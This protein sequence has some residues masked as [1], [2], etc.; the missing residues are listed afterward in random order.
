MEKSAND[1][2]GARDLHLH[3]ADNLHYIRSTIERASSVT[4]VSGWGGVV[5][6]L[7]AIAAAAIAWQQVTT[8]AWLFVWLTEAFIAAV[9]GTAAMALKSRAA[10]MPLLSRAA[11]QFALSFSP[12]IAAAG[13]LTVVCYLNNLVALL[14]G[15]WLLLY[16][17]AVVSGGTFSVRPIPLTGLAMML[18]GTVALFSPPAWGDAFMAAGFGGL[19]II[20][21]I[22][23][24]RRYGG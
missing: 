7:T 20:F 16:G 12:A 8:E 23:I 5:M 22:I 19:H 13:L 10:G 24:V 15:I 11:R 14:P 4:T 17:T 21:G 6:G 18:T 3:A 1:R 9:I 2:N